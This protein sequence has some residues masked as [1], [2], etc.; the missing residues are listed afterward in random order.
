MS[1]T[2]TT[3]HI[4]ELTTDRDEAAERLRD[5]NERV[6]REAEESFEVAGGCQ[7]C[8]G[9]G[10]VVTWD[11]LDC[12]Q[13]SY[14]EYDSCR[15]ESCTALTRGA[16]GYHPQNTKYDRNRGSKW[17]PA[18]HEEAQRMQLANNCESANGALND[19]IARWEPAKGKLVEV[20]RAGGGRKTYRIPVGTHGI[21]KRMFINDWGTEKALIL[22]EAGNKHWPAVS[23][24]QVID[25]D[26][27]T[28]AWDANEVAALERDGVPV[29]LKVEKVTAKAVLVS[30]STGNGKMWLPLSQVPA[31]ANAR[32]GKAATVHMPQWLAREKGLMPKE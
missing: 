18:A 7:H 24:L 11:T 9:R 6:R 1:M 31:L 17:H 12:M 26:P 22:D 16:S 32:E 13:G 15:E 2:G 8:R 10:W 30:P 19:E 28:A 5:H 14:A 23:L 20:V 21:V 27:D 3:D 29:L 4:K 25:P